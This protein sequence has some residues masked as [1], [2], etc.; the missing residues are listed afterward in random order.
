MKKLILL[1]AVVMIAGCAKQPDVYHDSLHPADGWPTY[2]C[3]VSDCLIVDAVGQIDGKVV[4]YHVGG[5]G[6]QGQWLDLSGKKLN[7]AYVTHK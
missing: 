4:T 6:P 7:A 2:I 1:A 3:P 5:N